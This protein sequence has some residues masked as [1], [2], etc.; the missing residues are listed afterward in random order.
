MGYIR[1]ARKRAKGEGQRAKVQAG[2]TLGGG[3]R[4]K[5]ELSAGSG[6]RL[7]PAGATAEPP[8]SLLTCSCVR[9]E[10]RRRLGG[11]DGAGRL[12]DAEGEDGEDG[13][14]LGDFVSG[15]YIQG[16]WEGRDLRKVGMK[17]IG[18][19]HLQEGVRV[20][21]TRSSSILKG[22]RGRAGGHTESHR[23]S[24]KC[25]VLGA[26]EG[27]LELN[28]ISLV[29]F[30]TRNM[31]MSLPNLEAPRS[32][33]RFPGR[34]PP[35]PKPFLSTPPELWSSPTQCPVSSSTQELSHA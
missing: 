33:P 23:M 13:G 28:S 29:I 24:H 16:L 17:V 32:S 31:I 22:G 7:E 1:K 11:R 9:W 4:S 35:P 10:G 21:T 6:S 15:G 18:R 19:R 3:R 26:K 20:L 14:Q 34:L 30:L 12:Q 5:R 8:G 25:E 2:R 27:C